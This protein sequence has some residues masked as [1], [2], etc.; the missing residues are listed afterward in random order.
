M[1]LFAYYNISGNDLPWLTIMRKK[2]I[3]MFQQLEFEEVM[4][5]LVHFYRDRDNFPTVSETLT[6]MF[7]LD[8]PVSSEDG[9]GG[10]RSCDQKGQ[11]LWQVKI[12]HEFDSD[13]NTHFYTLGTLFTKLVHF[14]LKMR[15]KFFFSQ[16]FQYIWS[17]EYSNKTSR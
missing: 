12:L 2:N 16:K 6:Q 10:D 13:R 3:K 5:N 7:E 15:L 14:K 1:N 9:D 11:P 4:K 17:F 8:D